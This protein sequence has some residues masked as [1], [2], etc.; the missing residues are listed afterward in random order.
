LSEVDVSSRALLVLGLVGLLLGGGLW[1]WGEDQKIKAEGRLES[2]IGGSI[3]NTIDP[4]NPYGQE[5][6]DEADEASDDVSAAETKMT[7]GTVIAV[8]SVL[9]LVGAFA[10]RGRVRTPATAGA[11]WGDPASAPPSGP[12]TG[13]GRQPCPECGE[14]IPVAARVC[15]F[16]R[17]QVST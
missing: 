12:D 1:L 4:S 5:S 11:T 6:A 17:H 3:L 14:S 9:L 7:A 16:C 13:E 15:R 10:M 8:L 2:N